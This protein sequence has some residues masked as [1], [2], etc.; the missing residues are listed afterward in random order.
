MSNKPCRCLVTSYILTVWERETS[1]RD[2]ERERVRWWVIS[3]RWPKLHGGHDIL[4]LGEIW[5]CFRTTIYVGGGT[6]GGR[7]EWLLPGLE[8]VAKKFETL[9]NV[10]WVLHYKIILQQ[11]WHQKKKVQAVANLI[12]VRSGCASFGIS[13]DSNTSGLRFES[14]H[15]EHFIMNIWNINCQKIENKEKYAIMTI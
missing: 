14:S 10:S 3:F 2:W 4:S 9:W 8:T 7:E 12:N 6:G 13:V 5:V 15:H 1:K 11:F